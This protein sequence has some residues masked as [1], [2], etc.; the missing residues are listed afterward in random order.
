MNKQNACFNNEIQLDELNQGIQ[1][2]LDILPTDKLTKKQTAAIIDLLI[3]GDIEPSNEKL[4][5]DNLAFLL[6]NVLIGIMPCENCPA[7]ACCKQKDK[8]DAKI[9]DCY[10][11]LMF[12]M[13]A[14]KRVH[15][16]ITKSDVQKLIGELQT[17]NLFKALQEGLKKDDEQ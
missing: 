15:E 1:V 3:R 7:K 17:N 11:R 12:L 5:M 13:Q 4:K 10:Q 14:V 2:V 8:P 9:I 16:D 6:T